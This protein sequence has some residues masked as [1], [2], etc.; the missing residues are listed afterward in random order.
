MPGEPPIRGR[1]LLAG[2]EPGR[3]LG[4]NH[5]LKTFFDFPVKNLR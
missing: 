1:P 5:R 4:A 2:A 3:T